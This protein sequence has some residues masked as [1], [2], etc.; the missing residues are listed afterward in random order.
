MPDYLSPGVYIQELEGPAPIVGVSTSIA[1]FIG[2][3]ERGPVNVP[4]LCTSPGDYS[5]WFGGLLIRGEFVDP[6]DSNRA[7]CYLPYAVAGFFNNSGQIAYVMRVLPDEASAAERYLY[8]RTGSSAVTTTLMRNAAAGSGTGNSPS[9]GALIAL[10]P[11]PPSGP[12]SIIRIGDGSVSEYLQVSAAAPIADAFALDLPLQLSHA[13]ATSIA[14]YART[15]KGGP[16]T[17]TADVNPGDKTI[18]VHSSDALNSF[19]NWVVELTAHGVSAIVIPAAVTSAG[20]NLFAITLTQP[21]TMAFSSAAGVSAVTALD[22]APAPASTLDAD[23]SGGDVILYASGG[24][25]TPGDLIDI[26]PVHPA[27][28][29][30]RTIGHLCELAFRQPASAS[31][32][33]KSL[34]SPVTLTT[35]TATSLTAAAA[36]GAQLVSLASRTG[37]KPGTILLLGTG[38]AQEY[39]AVLAVQGARTLGADPGAVVLEEPLTGSHPNGAPVVPA[40]VNAAAPAGKRATPII[41]DVAAGAAMALVSWQTGW[42]AGDIVQITL[43]DGTLAY[44]VIAAAPT[45]KTLEAVTLSS[46][47]QRTHQLGAPVVSRSPLIQVQAL[48][49]GAWGRRIA[50]AVQDESPGLVSR[51]QIVTL[52]GPTQLQLAT[53]TGIEPGSYLEMLGPDGTVIDAAHPLKVSHINL[54]TATITLDGAISASQSAAIGT[55]TP[56]APVV[57]RS[58][59]FRLTVYLYRHPDPAV[60]SRN[61][62]VIQTEVFRN[63]S[64]D[65]RHSRYFQTVIGAINGPLRLS[66][67]RPEGASWLIRTLDTAT[68]QANQQAAR[69]GPEALVDIL[70]SGLQRP[71]QFK[72][73]QGGDDSIATVSDQMYIGQDDAEPLNRTGIYALQNVPQISIVAIPGQATPAIQAALIAHCENSLYRFAVLDPRY[74]DSGLADIQA[75]RQAFDTKHAAIYYPWLTI[76]DP[77]PANPASIADFPLPPSGHV[78]GIYARV[79]DARGVFKAPANEVVQGI[80]G[81]TRSLVKGDQDILNPSPVNINVIR[82]FRREGRG[83]RVWGSRVMT[84]DETRK[85]V[86]VQRLMMFLEQSLDVGLQGVVFEPNAPPLWASVERRIANFLTNVWASGALQGAAPEQSFFVRC[87]LTT[88]TQDDIDAGRLI[89]LVGVAPVKPAEF[90]IIQIALMTAANSQ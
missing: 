56:A 49:R 79:D 25:L 77:L 69:L 37:I 12:A 50:I 5:R 67:R 44:N 41:L 73:D 55:A 54:S 16:Y 46:P 21:V 14:A 83:I 88:M 17:L 64:M 34:I 15:V 3:A 82:D 58:R 48:D 89:A 84:S 71:A 72:L 9:T 42:A 36:A 75:Q 2:M 20:T 78:V 6:A 33:A 29:E 62:Q 7:H 90:V 24:G 63:L 61:M 52:V 51:A 10:S 53:L 27:T 47:V 60:P 26:D 1:G 23:A 68:T 11:V 80:T 28:R 4:I 43:P 32:P 31:W 59:E 70:P 76:P 40:S 45:S 57:L 87:D 85:Y 39:A 81:L 19:T 38:P 30:I 8:D 18:Y 86:P 66:D 22:A 74:P 65:P 35:A 13:A